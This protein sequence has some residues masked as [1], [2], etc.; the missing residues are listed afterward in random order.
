MNELICIMRETCLVGIWFS[1]WCLAFGYT[2]FW[3]D[4][5]WEFIIRWSV[6]CRTSQTSIIQTESTLDIWNTYFE[7]LR[8]FLIKRSS[9]LSFQIISLNFFNFC[10]ICT[11]ERYCDLRWKVLQIS[12]S[13][14][15]KHNKSTNGDHGVMYKTPQKSL[16]NK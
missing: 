1:V 11:S 4:L 5:F 2:Y 12:L 3:V 13:K 9:H 15:I 16:L 6:W 8:E 10:P 14:E 7:L